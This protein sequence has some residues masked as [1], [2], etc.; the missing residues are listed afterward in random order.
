M[1]AAYIRAPARQVWILAAACMIALA[2]CDVPVDRGTFN[3]IGADEK[4]LVTV[5][6]SPNLAISKVD[7][8]QV[9]WTKPDN[10]YSQVVKMSPGI[11]VFEVNYNDGSTWT[12]Q[13]ISAVAKLSTGGSY[14]ISQSING[15][16]ISIQ[17]KD[18]AEQ[19]AL[20]NM[21][22]LSE[23]DGP[24]AVY[25]INVFNPTLSNPKAKILVS[26]DSKEITFE[27]DLV[28]RL[29]DKTTGRKSEGRYAIEMDFTMGGRIYFV[30]TDIS[31]LSSEAFLA[32]DF[33][34]QAQ[35]IAS[36]ILCDGAT[37]TYNYSKPEGLNGQEEVFTIT[38]LTPPEA[39]A[40]KTE[41][42]AGVDETP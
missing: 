29:T 3:P 38:N 25:V 4:Q 30:E 8:Y 34:Q 28:Y 7:N 17:I 6:I 12:L 33:R 21:N 42:A 36:P 27:H 31:T 23:D 24:L 41:E 13:P 14:T 35:T 32:G 39:V 37:V 26:N 9:H 18:G 10:N 20:F 15:N 5:K 19:S 22:S 40:E 1:K 2:S 11:H 16:S